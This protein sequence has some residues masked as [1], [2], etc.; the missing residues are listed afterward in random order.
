MSTFLL[1]S[2]TPQ[3]ARIIT[4]NGASAGLLCTQPNWE[5][6]VTVSL[7]LPTDIEREPITFYESRRAFAESAR[8]NM[9]WRAYLPNA[10]AAEELR[11]FLTR[12]RGE[13]VLVP[14]WTDMCEILAPLTPGQTTIALLDP[15]P[16]RSG[17]QWILAKAD[18]SQWEIVN[19]VS[20]TWPFL[21]I[22]PGV[23]FNW[24]IG[25]FIFPLIIG[26]L[27]DR[28]KPESITDE[29]FEVDL[30]IKENSDFSARL[31]TPVTPDSVRIVGPNIPTFTFTPL[32]GVQ[33]NYVKPIDWTEQPDIIY[34][35]LGFLRQ[36]QQR[37]F[38]HRN[39]RG[40]QFEFYQ[41]N[42]TDLATIE[43]FWRMRRGPVLRFMVPT[44]R[45]DMRMRSDAP[46]AGFPTRI[47]VEDSEFCDPGREP[48]PGDP[49]I[50][51]IFP[52]GTP[53]S[54]LLIVAPYQLTTTSGIQGAMYLQA[55]TN[56]AGPFP[57]ATTTISHLLL[58]RFQE[59]TLQWTYITPY[60]ASATIKFVELPHEYAAPP[61]ALPEPAYLFVFT[62]VGVRTDRFTSYENTIV[63]PSGDW[64]GTYA[65][66]PFSFQTLKTGLKLDQVKLDFKS[67]PFIGNP[68]NK[69]WPFALDGLL[70]LDVVEVDAQ[71]PSSTTAKYRFS[72]EITS[73][74]SEYNATAVQFGNFF[75][76]KFPRFLLSVTD[77]YTE[78]TPPTMLNALAFKITGT[79]TSTNGQVLI[80]TSSIA[81]GEV[82]DYF[83]GGWLEVGTG[84]NFERRGILHSEPYLTIGVTLHIDRPLIKNLVGIGGPNTPGPSPPTPSITNLPD[85]LSIDLYPG[86]D[87]S[88]TQCDTKFNNRIN[89]G[90]HA[91]IPNVNPAVKAM[92]PKPLS[93]GKK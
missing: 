53:G 73:V 48:Q 49:F 50:C 23:I 38:D 26:R 72:G 8:Y 43:G 51:L 36:E 21:H 61:A 66:A 70:L 87:G 27:I 45:G 82:T 91:Y 68:L 54:S 2:G 77:N 56:I 41:N 4:Y 10:A 80:V 17:T 76:R 79:L 29:T 13:P 30:H 24:A 88:I 47:N 6:P 31:S 12:I 58:A 69:L 74:D 84:V 33:P 78:F 32:F 83:S 57:A 81:H 44:W 20:L 39:A 16:V 65:P 34:Y 22:L 1:T 92:K 85:V 25:D 42:R 18:F 9:Q 52:S 60:L 71:A 46:V 3:F 67:F 11:I 63:V 35:D 15:A 37:V 28:P 75:D 19:A 93:G 89:F 62:E 90:G 7:E 40:L 5:T 55:S 64:A 14:M 59:P 86:Y